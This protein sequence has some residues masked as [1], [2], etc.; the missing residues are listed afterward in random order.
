[1]NAK[2]MLSKYFIFGKQSPIHFNGDEVSLI[3]DNNTYQ[4][5]APTVEEKIQ[6]FFN[7]LATEKILFT[8]PS[9]S[10]E[11]ISGREVIKSGI[12]EIGLRGFYNFNANFT[13]YPIDATGNLITIDNTN[14]SGAHFAGGRNIR[15]TERNYDLGDGMKQYML[16]PDGTFTLNG[17]PVSQDK[18]NLLTLAE[19]AQQGNLPS[20]I[21]EN[22]SIRYKN[23]PEIRKFVADGI[24]GFEGVYLIRSNGEEW[25]YDS[26]KGNHDIRLYKMNSEEGKKLNTALNQAITDFSNSHMDD[27]KK[28]KDASKN[29]APEAPAAPKGSA[30]SAPNGN[31]KPKGSGQNGGQVATQF[32]GKTLDDFDMKDGGLFAILAAN[33][34]SPIIK[35]RESKNG[36]PGKTGVFEALQYAEQIGVPFNSDIIANKIN[37]ILSAPKEQ[38]ES[39][40]DELV[41]ELKGCNR[42]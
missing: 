18:Q 26:R 8:L 24:T 39:M 7:A 19:Q 28:L 4:L 17:E 29:E 6:Q 25:I 5:D 21:Q 42:H 20:F 33:K 14:D 9:E 41:N 32:A 34:K 35:G 1:M 16:E 12:F 36:K 40:W 2:V 11:S 27:I 10:I 37:A 3:L 13:V 15:A 22:L 38:K 23:S 31:N 30:V